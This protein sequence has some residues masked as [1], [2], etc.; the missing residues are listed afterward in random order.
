MPGAD[1]VR[2]GDDPLDRL[3]KN[4]LGLFIA[5]FTDAQRLVNLLSIHPP[6]FSSQLSRLTFRL[7]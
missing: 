2:A 7:P 1:V 5:G 6:C 3:E 4:I